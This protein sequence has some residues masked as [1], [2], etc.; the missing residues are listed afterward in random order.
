MT[1]H[2]CRERLEYERATPILRWS[3]LAR[4]A[5]WEGWKVW[6]MGSYYRK[7]IVGTRRPWIADKGSIFVAVRPGE[8]LDLFGALTPGADQG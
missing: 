5:L 3:L 4:R 1:A 8:Q 7:S 2:L 6:P